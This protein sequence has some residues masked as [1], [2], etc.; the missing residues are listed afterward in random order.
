MRYYALPKFRLPRREIVVAGAVAAAIVLIALILW[1]MAPKTG[2]PLYTMTEGIPDETPAE[3]PQTKLQTFLEVV[4]GCGPDFEGACVNVRS[5][6]GSEYPSVLK[7]RTGV[8]LRVEKRMEGADREWLKVAQDNVRY[9]ER[10]TSDWY[11]AADV[12]RV[13]TD[14]GAR[15]MKKSDISDKTILV[16]RSDQ[17]L[18]AYD[19]ETLF[20][21]VSISTGHDLTPT[22][23]GSFKVFHKTPG[24]YMQG[25]LPGISDQYYDLPGVPWNLYF[26]KQGA[27]IHGAYWHDK[28]GEQWSHGCVN[29]PPQI[30]KQLYEWADLGTVVTVRD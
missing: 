23:R 13:F 4:D 16:D 5:G 1:L 9:P 17:M 12:V 11:V 28:F 15:D 29:V 6:P 2:M 7:L 21:E 10:I 25:P 20:M 22:P 14:V 27:V 24:R 26:T 18:Y 3:V 19:G 8:V 30:A